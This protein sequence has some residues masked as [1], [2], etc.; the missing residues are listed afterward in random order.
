[1]NQTHLPSDPDGFALAE[2]CYAGDRR[3]QYELWGRYKNRIFGVC[4]RYTSSRQ[5][6][7]DLLQESFVHVFQDI[8]KY[9][10]EGS[11]EGWMRRIVL[12]T[13]LKHVQKQS[14]EKDLQNDFDFEQVLQITEQDLALETSGEE[15]RLLALL[16]QLPTGFRTVLN[17]YVIEERSHEQIARELGISISTSKSQLNRAKAFMRRLLDKTML[18]L[19]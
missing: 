16:Q 18:L 3:A 19:V 13:V 9:R 10:G 12:R 14:I 5:E 1:M 8:G 6:A 17:L 2:A 7:E 11:L 15:G 4:L